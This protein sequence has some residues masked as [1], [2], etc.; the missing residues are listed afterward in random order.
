MMGGALRTEVVASDE[1]VY[2][3]EL[4]DLFAAIRT[5]RPAKIP[6]RE[7]ARSLDLA[8]AATRSAMTGMPILL[9]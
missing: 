3:L 6:M 4:L 8:L 1:D 2:K 9:P 5:G 7:G